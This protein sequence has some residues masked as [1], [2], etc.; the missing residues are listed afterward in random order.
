[1]QASA[2]CIFMLVLEMQAAIGAMCMPG[3]RYGAVVQM[4]DSMTHLPLQHAL[5]CE[6]CACIVD[7]RCIRGEVCAC[8]AQ[9][10]LLS[11]AR[12]LNPTPELG[13]VTYIFSAGRA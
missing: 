3:G 12:I 13:A 11:L 6:S 10:S 7:S 2:S 9:G 8:G 1:M 5:L 4:T